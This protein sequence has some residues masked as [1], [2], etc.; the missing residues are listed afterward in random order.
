MQTF[1]LQALVCMQGVFL[2]VKQTDLFSAKTKEKFKCPWSRASALDQGWLVLRR[3]CNL[4]NVNN[5]Q[6]YSD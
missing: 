4:N 1:F 5:N 6:V 3:F 2:V